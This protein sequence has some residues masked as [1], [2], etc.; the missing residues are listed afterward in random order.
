MHICHRDYVIRAEIISS[1]DKLCRYTHT[2]PSTKQQRKTKKNRTLK[3]QTPKHNG[4][5]FRIN[6]PQFE[7]RDQ[8]ENFYLESFQKFTAANTLACIFTTGYA[9][10]KVSTRVAL[11]KIHAL[12]VQNNSRP[13]SYTTIDLF[14]R[15]DSFVHIRT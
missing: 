5:T 8:G 13:T 3:L 2:I 9:F 10:S 11:W 4:T 6:V 12:R 1:N 7:K 15:H 14:F